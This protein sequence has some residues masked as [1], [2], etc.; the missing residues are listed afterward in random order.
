MNWLVNKL[1]R[2]S[3]KCLNVKTSEKYGVKTRKISKDFSD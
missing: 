3:L 1:R 2:T